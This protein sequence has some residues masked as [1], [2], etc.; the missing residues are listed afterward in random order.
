MQNDTLYNKIMNIVFDIFVDVDDP[1]YI[2]KASVKPSYFITNDMFNPNTYHP[3]FIR[4]S[5]IAETPGYGLTEIGDFIVEYNNNNTEIESILIIG[6]NMP[7]NI[8]GDLSTDEWSLD[9]L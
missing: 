3:V 4:M 6:D 1:P 5:T 8:I 2:K 7:F 9:I